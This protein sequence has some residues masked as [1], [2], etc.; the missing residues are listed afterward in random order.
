MFT[1]THF[2]LHCISCCYLSLINMYTH[3]TINLPS[4]LSPHPFLAP[5]TL[6]PAPPPHP[7]VETGLTGVVL[8]L[9]AAAVALFLVSF[10][11]GR[12]LLGDLPSAPAPVLVLLDDDDD[13]GKDSSS[14]LLTATTSP[15]RL[16]TAEAWV[17]RYIGI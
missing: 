1:I 17:H 2:Y 16:V 12:G 4:S 3:S 8:V 5:S 15:S 9:A 7:L 10:T 13:E 14:L 6:H 11:V